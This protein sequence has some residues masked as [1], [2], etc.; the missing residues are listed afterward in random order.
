IRKGLAELGLGWDAPPYPEAPR[1]KPGPFEVQIVG[2]EL[3]DP[4]KMTEYLGQKAV[5]DLY[6]N[7]FDADAH[8]RLGAHLPAG[9]HA[10]RAHAHLG[11][12]L[13]FRPDL[14][15]ALARR[16]RAAYLLRRW[17]EAI[18]DADKYLKHDPED[19]STRFLRANANRL[20]K[21]YRDAIR[22]YTALIQKYPRD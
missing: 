21:R 17:E 10:E 20:A 11:T 2:A 6:F 14:H 15:E 4:K 12:A 19:R 3:M 1:G 8:Y 7:P 18:K 13:A 22:D 9:G 16:A 5:A